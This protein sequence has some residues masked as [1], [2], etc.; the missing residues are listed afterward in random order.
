MSTSSRSPSGNL[1][2][3]AWYTGSAGLLLAALPAMAAEPLVL[4]E[5]LNVT[6]GSELVS[7]PFTAP[8]GACVTESIQ[9]TGP[10]GPVA[11]QLTAIEAWPGKNPSVKSARLCFVVDELKPLTS[12]SYT[13][14]FGRK[15]APAVAT[16]LRI[17]QSTTQVEI[18]TAKVGVRL[19]LGGATFAT[20]VPVKDV[21]GPLAG[22]RLG[23][24]AWAGGSALTGDGLVSSWK[25]DLVGAG[26]VLARVVVT[27]TFADGNVV[28]FTA[29]VVAGDSAVRWDMM[30]KDDQPAMGVDFR[31]PPVPGVKQAV[32]LQGYGQWSRGDRV[33]PLVPG[34]KPFTGISP[35]T[36]LANVFPDCSWALKLAAEG[37]V[38]LRI[39]SRDPAAWADPVAPM[40]YGGFKTWHLEMIDKSWENW[41]RKRLPVSYAADGTVTLAAN[42]AKGGRRWSVSNGAPILGDALDRVKDMVLAWPANPKQPH[43]R[44]FVDQAALDD[45]WKRAVTDTELM[46]TVAQ[47]PDAAGILHLLMKPADK[48]TPAEIDAALKPLRSFLSLLGNFDMMRSAIRTVTMYDVAIDSGLLSPEDRTL[49]RAQMAYMAYQLADPQTW[50]MERGYHSGN[51]NMS[52][53]YTLSL[54]VIACALRDHPMAATWAKR[55]TQWQEKWLT[56]EVGPNGEWMSE[57]SH[58][59]TVSLEP[60]VTYAV[61]AQRAGFHDFT[62]DPR[63]KKFLLYYAKTQTPRDVQR[64]NLRATGAWGRGTS[65]DKHPFFG[66]AA[67][68]TAT[69]DPAFSQTMQWMWSELGYPVFMGDGRLGGCEPY[70]EDR[71]LPAQTPA[72]TTELFPNLGVF[73]RAAFNTPQESYL[74][75]LS[76]TDSLRNLDVWTPGIGSFSQ[77]FGRGKPLSTCFC[78]DTGYRVRHDL[79]RD[80]VRLARNWGEPGDAKGPFGY[81]TK[82]EP[83]AIALQPR[84]DYVRTTVINTKVDDR[85]WFPDLAPP[86]Y[87]RVTAAKEGK[88]DWTRQ[89]LFLRDA[90]A[91]GP[92]YIVVRDTTRGGQPTAWQFWTLSEKLGTPEQTK[93]MTSFLADK[94]GQK[95]M[96][97]RELPAGDRY[98]AV[99]QFDMDVEFFLASPAATPRHTLRYGGRDNGGVPQ[100]QDLLHLQLPGDGTYYLVLFPRPRTEAAPT[101]TKLADGAILKVAGAF[102]TDYAFLAATESSAAAEGAAFKGTAGAIQTRAAATTLSLA[103]AGEVKWQDVTLQAPM[104]AAVEVGADTLTVTTPS[105]GQGGVLTLTVPGKLTVKDGGK[106][107]SLKAD[108]GMQRLTVPAGAVRVVLTR[109]K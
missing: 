48:R 78:S 43:P 87:P 89:V 23:T 7:Y 49:L 25:A 33:T 71:R 46:K 92:A 42:F 62:N 86:A 38:E 76:H 104:A 24:G 66:C 39:T 65:G 103:A 30:S 19:P 68:M 90:D 75:L 93:D 69:A 53:S 63:L 8:K 107:V 26:P 52:C 105:D 67:R 32:T 88:L 28:A 1:R 98:T 80:G 6:Y 70:Y 97:A 40:T 83:Q 35:N 77:W 20:P 34:D 84:V 16:D 102:G 15:T 11:A 45:V 73:F 58:Y 9:V 51:P 14:A 94:P 79:L 3:N 106:G 95:L 56:D 18:T 82:T 96:P 44:L 55:A 74:I 29:T 12:A 108:A 37:G 109:G 64:G 60:F 5:Q 10:R 100:Y 47:N 41:K 72:W 13:V 36:S 85:D 22:T 54:G 57:G 99:G 91:A 61:A 2:R 31:L 50:D 81:Y 4:R 21:P 17:S 59:G 27:Y 101:F